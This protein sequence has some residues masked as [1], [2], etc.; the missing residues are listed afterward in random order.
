[1]KSGYAFGEVSSRLTGI[2]CTT[3]EKMIGVQAG[4]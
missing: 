3:V 2:A 4:G 1:M